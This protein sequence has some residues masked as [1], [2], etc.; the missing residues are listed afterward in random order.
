MR[1]YAF[2]FLE[3]NSEHVTWTSNFFKSSLTFRKVKSLTISL[4]KLTRLSVNLLPRALN[5][6]STSHWVTEEFKITIATRCSIGNFV[7]RVGLNH[8]A[9]GSYFS[10][11]FCS[12][13]IFCHCFFDWVDKL[14][15][16]VKIVLHKVS[17][18]PG[19]CLGWRRTHCSIFFS[20]FLY[21]GSMET[22]SC[23]TLPN[24]LIFSLNDSL[25]AS[26]WDIMIFLVF[27]SMRTSIKSSLSGMGPRPM[28][29]ISLFFRNF[30]FSLDLRFLFTFAWFR[31]FRARSF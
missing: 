18:S 8:V 4:L 20:V 2:E 14:E 29:R 11:F 30:H 5:D 26:F 9:I 24:L 7:W 13:K 27:G 6:R 12:S 19:L 23:I 16:T 1:I 25:S 15:L 10:T 17:W 28:T 3:E 31:A 21:S 22:P